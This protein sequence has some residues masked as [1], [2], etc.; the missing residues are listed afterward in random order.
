MCATLQLAIWSLFKRGHTMGYGNGFQECKGV[1]R[2][3]VSIGGENVEAFLSKATCEAAHRQV[4]ESGSLSDYYRQ[5]QSMLDR[6]VLD[7]VSA[8][9]RHPVVLM[10]RDLQTQPA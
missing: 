4:S 9:A 10:A 6:I 8:G 3:Q 5:Y 1:L 7:K 2:F